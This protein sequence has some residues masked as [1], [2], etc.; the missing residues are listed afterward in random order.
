MRKMKA[1]TIRSKKERAEAEKLF[2][3]CVLADVGIRD[4]RRVTAEEYDISWRRFSDRR[5]QALWRAIETLEFKGLG[6]RSDIVHDELFAAAPAFDPAEVPEGYDPVAGAPGTAMRKEYLKKVE[7]LTSD[8]AWIERE[9]E[10]A[11]IIQ[12]VGGKV[13]LRELLGECRV[14]YL[15][16][17]YTGMEIKNVAEMRIYDA[18]EYARR[19]GFTRGKTV[20]TENRR[21]R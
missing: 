10:A 14:Y 13:Y 1:K 12:L 17:E 18:G 9:L 3:S 11:G 8:A 16:D 21:G 6:E 20:V 19:L 15:D 4:L 2:L 5:H 7:A